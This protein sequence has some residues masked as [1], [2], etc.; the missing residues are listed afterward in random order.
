MIN[1]LCTV[2]ILQNIALI[3]KICVSRIESVNVQQFDDVSDDLTMEMV[4]ANSGLEEVETNDNVTGRAIRSTTMSKEG[5][6]IVA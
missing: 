3:C 5:I 6:E 4:A 1:F 2:H